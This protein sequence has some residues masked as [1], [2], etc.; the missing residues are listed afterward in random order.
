VVKLS[1]DEEVE[2]IMAMSDEEVRHWFIERGEDPN[3]VALRVKE[4]IQR[5]IKRSEGMVRCDTTLTLRHPRTDCSC[6]TYPDNLGPCVEFMGGA[7][8]GHC[9]F[10]D[11]EEPCHHEKG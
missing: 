1:I 5:A 4:T 3:E 11:H 9:V 10:C 6:N 8:P 2:K 7:F